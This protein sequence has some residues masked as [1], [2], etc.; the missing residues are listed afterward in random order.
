MNKSIKCPIIFKIGEDILN[1]IEN[2]MRDGH[3][4]YEEKILITQKELFDLYSNKFNQ[5]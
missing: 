5:S 2:I 1:S 3:L 4:Y